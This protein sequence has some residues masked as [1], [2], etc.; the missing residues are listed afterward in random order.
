MLVVH[1]KSA[2]RTHMHMQPTRKHT[3]KAHVHG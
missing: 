1:S 3:H 2:T